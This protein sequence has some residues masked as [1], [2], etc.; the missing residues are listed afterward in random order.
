MVRSEVI[1]QFSDRLI[2]LGNASV[3]FTRIDE[4]MSLVPLTSSRIFTYKSSGLPSAV[5]VVVVVPF[6]IFVSLSWPFCLLPFVFCW[7]DFEDQIFQMCLRLRWKH[8][9]LAFLPFHIATSETSWINKETIVVLHN[10]SLVRHDEPVTSLQNWSI[11]IQSTAN[12]N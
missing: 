4:K 12:R 1:V 3:I 8:P 10:Q 11:R 5:V 7:W 9:W 6:V 2:G